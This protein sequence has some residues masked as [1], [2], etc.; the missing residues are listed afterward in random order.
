MEC[1]RKTVIV[2]EMIPVFI[3]HSMFVVHSTRY[4]EMCGR[5]L[6]NFKITV[7]NHNYKIEIFVF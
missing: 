5:S 4:M 2:K 3:F 7:S 6:K 1:N